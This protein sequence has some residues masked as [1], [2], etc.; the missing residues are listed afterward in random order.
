MTR[1]D[2]SGPT[3]PWPQTGGSSIGC[4]TSP[5]TDDPRP[6]ALHNALLAR[7]PGIDRLRAG[8]GRGFDR[9]IGGQTA[10]ALPG[11]AAA[12]GATRG[13]HRNQRAP[14]VAER[15]PGVARG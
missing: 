1:A 14:L 13:A 11:A 6:D 5:C 3:A 15:L 7:L 9:R 10:T 4:R 8:P 12:Q 2:S